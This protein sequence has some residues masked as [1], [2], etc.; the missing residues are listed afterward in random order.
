MLFQKKPLIYLQLH[1]QSMRYMAVR[2]DNHEIIEHDEIFFETS[3]LADGEISNA[4][5]LEHV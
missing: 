5:L 1:E 2:P 4:S 3:M